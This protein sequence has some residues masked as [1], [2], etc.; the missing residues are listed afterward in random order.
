MLTCSACTFAYKTQHLKGCCH[1]TAALAELAVALRRDGA[2]LPK[3]LERAP[4]FGELQAVWDAQLAVASEE[5][6]VRLLV[7]LAEV[8]R[9]R[10][11]GLLTAATVEAG[12]RVPQIPWCA[13]SVRGFV[14]TAPCL[15]QD[16]WSY[17]MCDSLHSRA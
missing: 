14:V 13:R 1:R 8:L 17:A 2:L 16:C 5:V 4:G 6:L 10:N 9:I 3:L 15:R 7:L 12:A 11:A